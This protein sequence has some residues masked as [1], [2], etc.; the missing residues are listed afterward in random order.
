MSKP[1]ADPNLP[2]G[3]NPQPAPAQP[4]A[5][6]LCTFEVKVDLPV[7]M[8]PT[9]MEC[10]IAQCCANNLNG[11][12]FAGN[13]IV[14][15]TATAGNVSVLDTVGDAKRVNDPGIVGKLPPVPVQEI[16]AA[17]PAVVATP[18]AVDPT[19]AQLDFIASTRLPE[20]Q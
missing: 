20:S 15:L 13:V 7:T 19:A 8:T 10:L 1:I 4:T 11:L 18:V 6:W 12:G 5:T 17:G 14:T 16:P 2:V 9:E 3:F